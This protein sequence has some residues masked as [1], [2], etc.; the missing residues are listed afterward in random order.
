MPKFAVYYVPQAN[1]P[2]YRLG[3]QILGY[4]SRARTL[5]PLPSDIRESLGQFDAAWTAT[6]R[7]YGFH[8]TISEAIDCHWATIPSLER[9][10]ADLLACFDPTHPFVLQRHSE[11]PVGIWGE[12]GKRSL[13]L[14]YEPN[15]HLC[16]LHTLIVARI[17]S[18][19]TGSS[20]LKRYFTH[21]EWELPPHEVQQ[22]RLFY[23]PK[24]FGNW[25]PHF[26]LLNPYT[27]EDASLMA[28]RLAHLF[29]PYEQITVQAVCLL[30]QA[31]DE[32]NWQIYREFRRS[33]ESR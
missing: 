26:T 10:L 32:A 6:S 16:M 23:S 21:H 19:G 5:V 29:A 22:L 3:S 13:V 31:H 7:P 17:N 15:E 20:Y 12:K 28:S 33:L 2:F 4:D 24:V 14:L 8:L 18:Q 30:I 11:G 25:C 27:G 9:E 1:D